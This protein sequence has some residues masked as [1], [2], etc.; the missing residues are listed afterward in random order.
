MTDR[1]KRLVR[2]GSAGIGLY[3]IL[4]FLWKPLQKQRADYQQLVN[5]ALTL[6]H[7]IQPYET[8]AQTVKKLMEGFQ[9]DPAKLTKAAVV[10]EAS[11]AIQNAAMSSGIQVGSVRESSAQAAVRELAS[12]QF[13]GTG[14][15]QAVMGLL[16]RM[17][18][19]GFPL[20][21][22]SVQIT[23]DKMKPGQVKMVLTVVILDFER[24]KNEDEP[25]A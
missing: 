23:P 5:S 8:R 15:V 24:W 19:L 9:M 25:H 6:K 11:T 7:R 4:F 18:S 13:E 16:K 10:G 22:D 20:I 14:P 21:I 17:E 3:L 2:F 12:V 1:E